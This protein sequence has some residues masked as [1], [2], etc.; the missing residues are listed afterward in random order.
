VIALND[1]FRGAPHLPDVALAPPIAGGARGDDS[2]ESG[3]GTRKEILGY[4]VS[5]AHH[6]DVSGSIPESMPAATGRSTR[7]ASV[8]RRYDSFRK[9][10]SSGPVATRNQSVVDINGYP[11]YVLFDTEV[12]SKA[13]FCEASG[14]MIQTEG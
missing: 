1:P 2:A 10:R 12:I 5:L 4:A 13:E 6:A 11:L 9:G 14:E 7:R 3:G 8:Y